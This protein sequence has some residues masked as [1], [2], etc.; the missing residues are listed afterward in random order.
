MTV[1][2]NFSSILHDV[3]FVDTG[4]GTRMWDLVG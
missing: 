1:P 4:L 3:A 2:S